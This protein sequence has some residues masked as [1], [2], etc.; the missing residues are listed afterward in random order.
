VRERQ[1]R[2]PAAGPTTLPAPSRS[3][4]LGAG[5]TATSV[6]VGISL[7]NFSCVEAFTNSI[8]VGE[9][10]IYQDYVNYINSHGG[11]SG[12]KIIPVYVKSRSSRST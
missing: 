8:R 11:I 1:H 6:K 3:A 4:T 5:V 2:N 10:A 12:R 9:Q 7:I